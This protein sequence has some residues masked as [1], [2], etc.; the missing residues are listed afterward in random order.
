MKYKL[1][2][3]ALALLAALCA[4]SLTS[5]AE[6][7]VENTPST[8]GY[9]SVSSAEASEEDLPEETENKNAAL[10][11]NDA[12]L[13]FTFS[14]GA[15]A[16]RTY[17]VLNSDGIFEGEY[18]D[19]EM[20]ENDAAYPNGTVYICAFKGNFTDIEKI[21]DFS[22][23]LS[24]EN[25]E[26]TTPCPQNEE[27]IENDI[28]YVSSEPYGIEDGTEFILYT[29]DTPLNEFSEEFL[30]WYTYVDEKPPTLLSCYGLYNIKMGY[31]FFTYE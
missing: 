29:P 27:W 12:P 24:L 19:S 21:S 6:K 20:G 13:E 30:M 15:G 23:S 9:Q 7:A 26:I 22:Y 11:P 31:G 18:T 14:S 16:W 25:V 8:S 1:K 5:C 3:L 10:L 28:R 17:L 2:A 4:F